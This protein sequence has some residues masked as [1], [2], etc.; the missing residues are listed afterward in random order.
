MEIPVSCSCGKTFKAKSTLA[1][2]TV[3]CPHC[4]SPISIP[5][6]AADGAGKIYVEI[7]GENSSELD[8]TVLGKKASRCS[9]DFKP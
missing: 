9:A 8:F 5:A 7:D 3:A 4:Q 2:K 1:G 6:A